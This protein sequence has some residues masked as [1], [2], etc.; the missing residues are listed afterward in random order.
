VKLLSPVILLLSLAIQIFAQQDESTVYKQYSTQKGFEVLSNLENGDYAVGL[1]VKGKLANVLTNFGELSSFHVASPSLEWPAFGEGQKDQQQYGWG[2]DLMVG[3]KGD[4]IESFQDPASNL[5]DRDWKPANENLFSGEITVSESDLTPIMA[6]SDNKLTW[7]VDGDGRPFWPGLF[8]EDT[9]GVVYPGQFS[10]ERDL[11]CVYTDSDNQTPYGIRVE[12][13]AYS[14]AR[15]YAEDFLVY[16]FNI[17]NTSNEILEDLYPG[18]IIQFLI[19]FDNHDLIDFVDSNNDGK[20]DLVYLWDEDNTPRDPWTKVG[21]I[22]LVVIS[23]PQ[24][25]GI[26]DFHY[27]HDDFIPSDD[28]MFW[29]LLTSDTTGLPDTTK[30]IYFHGDDIHIDDVSFAPGL[31]PEGNNAGG[32]ITWSFSSG[33]ISLAPSESVPLEIAIVCGDTKQDLLDNVQ[34]IWDLNNASWN[35]PNPPA[36]PIV[37]AYNG[38]G[39]VTVIWDAI[40]SEKS[41]DNITGDN[42]FEGYKVYRSTDRGK[43]WGRKITDSRGNFSSFEPIAQFDFVDEIKGNDPISNDYLGNNSGIKHTFVDT[44]VIN[45]IEYWYAV[46]AYD[47]GVEGKLESLE[48]ALGLTINE[49]NVAAA[50]PQAPPAN[51]QAGSIMTDSD[52]LLP[53][54]GTTGSTVRVKIIDPSLIKSRNYQLT[55]RENT[56]VIEDG[57]QIDEITTFTLKDKDTGEVLLA[58][59]ALSDSSSDNIP[60]IDGLLLIIHD[61]EPGVKKMG[62]TKV[63]G[64][65]C[66]FDWRTSSKYPGLVPGGEAFG[67]TIETFDDWRIT[68]DYNGGVDALWYDSFFGTVSDQTQFLPIRVEVITDPGNPVDVSEKTYLAEFSHGLTDPDIRSNF[69][70]PLGWDL[71]P[72]GLGY[73]NASPGW[74]E[75]HVDF[76]ILEKIDIDPASGDT[77]PN[78]M[79]LF[80]NNKP[81]TSFNRNSELEIIES[82]APSDG[83]EFEIIISKPFREG[84][85]YSFSTQAG[86]YT[87]IKKTD[88][89]KVKVVPNPFFVTNTLQDRV[90]FTSLPNQCDINIYNV[91]GDLIKKIHHRDDKGA[92]FWDLKNEHGLDI[93]YGLYIYV[94]KTDDGQKYKGKFSVIR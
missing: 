53:E 85:V 4:V 74:Y 24:N 76:L 13:T 68:V 77:I 71:V 41:K 67:E 21:Y 91:A 65:T 54:V 32:E 1:Q 87:A 29:R 69:Y 62:W 38:D 86:S 47:K 22:G 16:R 43:N 26:T 58:D 7:P 66:T 50:I 18:M 30:Q 57:Q 83:D 25:K 42:D 82:R 70:S 40:N 45:G 72:G 23:S 44:S 73:L 94:V 34:W 55:F 63:S 2:V 80:T 90:M 6:T 17:Q 52:F 84:V 81:D 8:R 33:P 49:K 56:P 14:F 59:H 61:V 75:K 89:K 93:A 79:Y 28:E 3:Y 60:I 37:E 15:G 27:F 10:S 19:D 36:S 12:Q 39:K 20:K 78:F 11:F 5:I 92:E 51:Y 31:D 88:L 9:A 48:S 64:D 46:T 35:G